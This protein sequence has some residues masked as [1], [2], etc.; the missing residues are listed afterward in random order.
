[1]LLNLFSY[2]NRYIDGKLLVLFEVT[3]PLEVTCHQLYIW[4]QEKL[5]SA[6]RHILLRADT[7][8]NLSYQIQGRNLRTSKTSFKWVILLCYPYSY[9]LVAWKNGDHVCGLF[10]DPSCITRYPVATY[11]T[12]NEKYKKHNQD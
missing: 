1:M 10:T 8:G 5:D 9:L 3:V 11:S 6:I 12:S 2:L 7:E 4:R